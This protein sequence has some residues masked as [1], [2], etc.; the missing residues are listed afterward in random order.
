[1]FERRR[2][3]T[4]PVAARKELLKYHRWL[5]VFTKAKAGDAHLQ[6]VLMRYSR[7]IVVKREVEDTK[8]RMREE[9][10]FLRKLRHRPILTGGYLRPTLYNPPLPRMKPQPEHVSGMIYK[11]R[12][13]TIKQWAALGET[14]QWL[15]DLKHE[16]EFEEQL[17]K[18][19][20]K[21]QV[22]LK[23]VFRDYDRWADPLRDLTRRT[24]AMTQASFGRQRMSYS[25]ELLEQIKQ[26][27]R[28]KVANKTRELQ[29]EARGEILNRTIFRA[30]TGP[31]AHVLAGMT[32][33]QK[34]LDKVSR[35]NV[36]EV[37]YVG[38]AKRRL[39]WKLRKPDA[40]KVEIGKPENKEV[41]DAMAEEIRQEN[42]RR[43]KDGDTLLEEK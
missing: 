43:R 2:H 37:G 34:H 33:L 32:S 31:P 28:E 10:E 1:M 12:K 38:W 24:K 40:W 22:S 4:S 15:Q 29:R 36:S 13:A 26:A 39:G 19:A 17:A 21:D 23:P 3:L 16:S 30:R 42:E 14:E 18:E 25:P 9:F 35:S 27:R 11:R 5:D 41:L 7:M 8:V 20:E 6:A